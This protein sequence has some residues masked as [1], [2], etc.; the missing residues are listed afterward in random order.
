MIESLVINVERAYIESYFTIKITK[1]EQQA[2]TANIYLNREDEYL[3]DKCKFDKTFK[4]EHIT[5]NFSELS[6]P[7]FFMFEIL[8]YIGRCFNTPS[9]S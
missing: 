3:W 5:N 7:G 8:Q 9:W 1:M 4:I 6:I 2:T